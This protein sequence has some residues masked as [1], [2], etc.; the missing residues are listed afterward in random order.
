MV[1][2]VSGPICVTGI[3]RTSSTIRI[4]YDATFYTFQYYVVIGV[5]LPQ[6]TLKFSSFYSFFHCLLNAISELLRYADRQ[7]YLDWWNAESLDIF[8]RVFSGVFRGL[9]LKEM[10]FVGSRVVA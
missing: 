10:E 9:I 2:H 5:T 4:R 8:W 3:K 7:F 1:T 6:I